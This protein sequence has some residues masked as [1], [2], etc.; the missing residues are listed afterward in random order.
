MRCCS[1]LFKKFNIFPLASE[2]LH[3][4]LLFVVDNV[5]KFQTNSDIHCMNT[6][7][8]Y[9]LHMLNGN[10]ISYKK[11]SYCAEVINSFLHVISC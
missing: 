3:S 9:N 7:H 10:L 1:E 5:E 2:F 4:L 8:K 11:D 6:R